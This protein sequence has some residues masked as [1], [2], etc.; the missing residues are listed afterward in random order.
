MGEA[1]RKPLTFTTCHVGFRH[2]L[3]HISFLGRFKGALFRRTCTAVS[4]LSPEQRNAA[5]SLGFYVSLFVRNV[6]FIQMRVRVHSLPQCFRLSSDESLMPSII[7][8]P[9]YTMKR[10]LY[11]PATLLSLAV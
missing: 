5:G 1:G 8:F 10:C 11:L 6:N 4:V 3:S 7:C 2:L 9:V